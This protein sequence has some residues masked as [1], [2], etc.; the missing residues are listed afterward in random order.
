[1]LFQ[2]IIII[3]RRLLS[4]KKPQ[5]NL[6]QLL[7]QSKKL[8]PRRKRTQLPLKLLLKSKLPLQALKQR[9]LQLK[10]KALELRFESR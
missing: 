3:F 1:M 9:K 2:L 5:L 10:F 8:N 7:K 4:K 6:P